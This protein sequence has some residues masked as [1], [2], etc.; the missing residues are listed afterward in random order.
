VTEPAT[1]TISGDDA[2][3]ILSARYPFMPINY[4][5]LD[6]LA[7]AI[8]ESRPA[9]GPTDKVIVH[10]PNGLTYHDD[11]EHPDTPTGLDPEDGS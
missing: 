7:A 1:I 11:R 4:D 6:R 5:V 8:I 3:A 10:A 2:E 9:V